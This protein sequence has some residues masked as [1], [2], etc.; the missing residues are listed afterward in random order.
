MHAI[1]REPGSAKGGVV[2]AQPAQKTNSEEF[3]GASGKAEI[4]FAMF[5]VEVTPP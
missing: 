3:C 2:V 5:Q 4:E 1:C